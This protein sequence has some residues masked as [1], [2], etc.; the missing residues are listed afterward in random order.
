MGERFRYYCS[1]CDYEVVISGGPDCGFDAFTETC[2]C[3]DCH[4]LVDVLTGY[5]CPETPTD[6][7]GEENDMKLC[8]QCKSEKVIAWPK[9]HPCPK[10]GSKMK[11]GKWV[12]LWD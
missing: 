11:K 12:L 9:S 6:G 7:S 8:P 4:E 2:L 3:K 5:L 10:C 1:F